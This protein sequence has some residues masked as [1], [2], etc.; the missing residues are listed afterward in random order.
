[1]FSVLLSLILGLAPVAVF[2]EDGLPTAQIQTKIETNITAGG[3]LPVLQREGGAEVTGSAA[4]DL[5]ENERQGTSTDRE[6]GQSEDNVK[7]NNASVGEQNDDEMDIERGSMDAQAS[8]TVG[9]ERAEQV[10][11]RN[12]LRRFAM[13]KLKADENAN[14]VKLSSTT[15]E[16]SYPT[17]ARLF[18]F[19]PTS[20]NTRVAINSDG[21]VSVTLPWYAFLFGTEGDKV[22]ANLEETVQATIGSTTASTT[23]TAQMQARLLE[24]ILATLHAS[25]S[26]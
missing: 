3:N 13:A 17:H 15:V 21:T 9:L 22:H 2:A 20:L 25:F 10:H 6:S 14:E 24:S 7:N 18:G 5:Q 1:M 19:I 26:N 4:V 8:S 12:A 16:A 11:D 23:L